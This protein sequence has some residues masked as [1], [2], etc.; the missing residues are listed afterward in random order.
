VNVVDRLKI[1]ETYA[2]YC[3]AVDQ[4]DVDAYVELFTEDA[5]VRS[6]EK[7]LCGREDL[8]QSLIERAA[9]TVGEPPTQHW[10]CN[11]LVQQRGTKVSGRCYFNVTSLD[12]AT[13][14]VLIRRRGIYNDDLV[15]VGPVWLF[16][17]RIMTFT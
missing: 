13:S 14:E 3:Y 16:A 6:P 5:I 10:I 2:R 7:D 8:R 1:D 11:L 4:N 9:R 15:K 12:P 17:S